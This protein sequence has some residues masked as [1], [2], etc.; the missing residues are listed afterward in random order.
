M[1]SI[2]RNFLKL[3][4]LAP[5]VVIFLSFDM[6]NRQKVVIS[7]DPFNSADA[8]LPQITVP[9]YAVLLAATAMGVLIGG[10]ATWLGQGRYRKAAR[11]AK[12]VADKLRLENETLRAQIQTLKAPA[13]APATAPAIAPAPSAA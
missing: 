8:I 10:I 9:L 4:L 13:A 12:G 2:M 7:F 11:G 1:G 3:L 6:A 5:I